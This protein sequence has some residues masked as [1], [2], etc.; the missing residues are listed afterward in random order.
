MDVALD[1]YDKSVDLNL[2]REAILAGN[3]KGLKLDSPKSYRFTDS[4]KGGWTTQLGA[5]KSASGLCVYDKEAESGGK[6][7]CHR[8][9]QRLKADYASQAL[10][11]WL[12]F[13]SKGFE[14]VS[15]RY[16][17]GLVV[18][19]YSFI[20]RASKP[21]EKNLSRI[22]ELPWWKTFVDRVGCQ[23]KHARQRPKF[24]IERKM[25]W[26]IR[27]VV[28]SLVVLDKV[29]GTENFDDWLRKEMA[30]A[31]QFRLTRWHW[32]QIQTFGAEVDSFAG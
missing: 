28:T 9:E 24:S 6:L 2:V 16:L 21:N 8:W 7:P 14:Q 29:M 10:D 1:D 11:D 18:G 4:A 25:R 26:I 27:Q 5:P 20:D 31:E 17:G 30:R 32:H 19:R 15:A 3:V 22:P 12:R 13:G 23:V